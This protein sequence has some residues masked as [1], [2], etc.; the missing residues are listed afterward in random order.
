MEL[1]SLVSESR[2]F[3]LSITFLAVLLLSH[4][5]LPGCQFTSLPTMSFLLKMFVGK[6]GVRF[7]GVFPMVIHS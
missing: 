3:L 6:N 7:L 4:V 5:D 2:N 1:V